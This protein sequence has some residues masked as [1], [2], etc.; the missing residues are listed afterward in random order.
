MAV[1]DDD[2]DYILN[3]I[4]NLTG[5]RLAGIRILDENGFIPYEHY[6]GFPCEF[7]ESENWLSIHNHNCACIRVITGRY[8]THDLKVV[9]PNGSFF[10]NHTDNFLNQ[11]NAQERERYRGVCNIFRFLSVA[12]IPLRYDSKTIGAIHLADYD[13][14]MVDISKVEFLEKVTPLIVGTIKST[15]NI[16]RIM[17]DK[18]RQIDKLAS[19]GVMAAGIAHEIN[20]PL[21]SLRII[22]DGTIYL[23]ETEIVPIEPV[24]KDKLSKMSLEINA[25]DT[26]IKYLYSL[27]NTKIE[28]VTCDLNA[29]VEETLD[30]F[31]QEI[32]SQRII[33]TKDFSKI[34]SINASPVGLKK[35]LDNIIKNSIQALSEKEENTKEIKC[36]TKM[37]KDKV[38]LEISDNGP[39]I[40]KDIRDRIFD[41]FFT[42][43]EPG[44]GMGLGL[45]ITHSSVS[46]MGGTIYL[47]LNTENGTKFIIEFPI[48]H[49]SMIIGGNTRNH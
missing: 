9:T 2:L 12:I 39:G 21:N 20:Q 5:C 29:T 26:V 40:N 8:E 46:A 38:L 49:T 11:L 43:K 42:T 27:L 7:W 34:P 10:C 30:L 32:L 16:T 19:L 17:E 24:I 15:S 47:D 22:V 1:E 44:N 4:M 13:E 18:K 23:S 25:I 3:Y 35:S 37:I 45:A 28:L 6:V 33:V 31:A 48:G 41:P 36:C 14:N